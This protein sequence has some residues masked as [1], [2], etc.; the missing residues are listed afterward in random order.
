[1]FEKIFGQNKERVNLG[2]LLDPENEKQSIVIL[3]GFCCNPLSVGTDEKLKSAVLQAL[4]SM[5][6]SAEI[7]IVS[8]TDAQ[9]NLNSLSDKHEPLAEDIKS[10]FQ[11]HGLKA[12]PALIINGKLA[13]YGGVPDIEMLTEKLK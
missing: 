7:H 13:F 2:K 10:I 12:F 5:H 1:M 3:S 8:I 6:K 9:Q 4:T 11:T